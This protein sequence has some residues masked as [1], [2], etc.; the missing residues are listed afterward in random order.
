ML[1]S[2]TYGASLKKLAP[3]RHGKVSKKLLGLFKVRPEV[4][5]TKYLNDL[6]VA[7]HEYGHLLEKEAAY[8]TVHSVL[9]LLGYDH[10]DEAGDKER[11]RERENE[12]MREMGYIS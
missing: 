1:L 8:L 3:W 5:R 12:I 2:R 6:P 10:V 9:H 4:I 7:M 11:M